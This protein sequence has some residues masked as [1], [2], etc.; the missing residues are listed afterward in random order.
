VKRRLFQARVLAGTAL[1]GL[2]A[3]AVTS[4]VAVL[5]IAA[6][7]VLVGAFALLVD[8]M[9]GLLSEFGDELQIVAYVDDSVSPAEQR[10]LAD[11]V[12]RIAGV[13]GVRVVSKQQA[14]ERF[15]GAGG[16]DLLDGLEGNPLP[17]SLEIALA[18]ERRTPEDIERVVGAVGDLAGVEDLAHGQDWVEGYSRAAALLRAGGIGLGALLG[19]ASLLIV[20]NTIRL[21]VYA[22][23]DELEI[24]SLV[25][26][27]RSFVRTPFVIEGTLQGALGGALAAL[28]LYG[29]FRLLLPQLE[30][31]L[32]FFLGQTA[33]HFFAAGQVTALIAGGAGLGMLGSL[34]AFVGWR[35]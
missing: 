31:G 32:A 4:A 14:L 3:S 20:A 28:L 23:E 10:D 27:S 34:L 17:A 35:S 12:L 18:P 29:A 19:V 30:Y 5:T 1:R 15:G 24:L 9:Q 2:Q 22:R 13:E 33:P 7:L 21:A 11:R 6:A 25:G 26:A 16:A 8:N